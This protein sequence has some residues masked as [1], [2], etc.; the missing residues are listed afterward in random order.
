MIF[1]SKYNNYQMS[2][3]V[4]GGHKKL[5]FV[6]GRLDTATAAKRTGM[7]EKKI[8]EALKG[9]PYFGV[10]FDVVPEKGEAADAS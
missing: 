7:S 10:D 5:V 2:V 9:S 8:V 6:D 3:D 1:V 4:P